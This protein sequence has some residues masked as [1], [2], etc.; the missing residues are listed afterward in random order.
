MHISLTFNPVC[1]DGLSHTVQCNKDDGIVHYIFLG[2]TGWNF[3]IMTHY[4]AFYQ[5]L[6]CLSKYPFRGFQYIIS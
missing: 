5:G 4:A 3:L 2:V 6:Y 1:T